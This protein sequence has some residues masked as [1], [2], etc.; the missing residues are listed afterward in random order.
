M[1]LTEG[2]PGTRPVGRG[3]PH[4]RLPIAGAFML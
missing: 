3:L 2:P 1:K 4:P